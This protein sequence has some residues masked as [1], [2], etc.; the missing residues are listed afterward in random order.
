M[1]DE[2]F[3]AAREAFGRRFRWLHDDE[4]D[5]VFARWIEADA[6]T[7]HRDAETGAISVRLGR[8]ITRH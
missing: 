8:R 2:E 1:S 7:F 6:L 4:I 5:E 3:D